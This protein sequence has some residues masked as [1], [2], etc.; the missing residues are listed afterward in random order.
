[1]SIWWL[2]THLFSVLGFVLAFLVLAGLPRERRAPSSTFAWLLVIVL[3]PYVGVP[4]Y[5]MFGPRKLR[6][7]ARGKEALY[8]PSSGAP[9][10]DAGHALERILRS[11]GAPRAIGGHRVELLATGEEAYRELVAM[12]E[13]AR[14]SIHIATFILGGDEVGRSILDLLERKAREGL[15]VRLL[16]DA[17]FG[18]RADRGGLERL[19]RAGGRYAFFMPVLHIPFRGQANLRN[20]RKI[21]LGDGREAIVGGMNIAREYMGPTPHPKRWRDVAVRIEGPTVPDLSRI[22]RLDWAFASKESLGEPAVDVTPKGSAH[23]QVAASGPD[24]PGDTIYDATLSALF[25]ARSRI[26]IATP[27]FIPDEAV[28]RGLV[29]AVRRGVDVR[30]VIPLRSNHWTADLAGG[31]YLRQVSDA[32]GR[33]LP[34]TG[35]MM[36]A[37]VA[38]IDETV[39][40]LGSANMD[41]RS[42]FVDYEVAL[43]FYSA[44]E[45]AL[46]A[47]WFEGLFRGCAESLSPASRARVLLENVGRLLA[48]LA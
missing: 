34:F 4:L 24:V 11:A 23:V 6:R 37:K 42:F 9:P 48:P 2:F 19:R 3:I 44:E 32:G 17:L 38:V 45:I 41:V 10:A 35:G 12:I 7:L 29:L 43:F 25:G 27:Y 26:W 16:I 8:L 5:L 1:V 33:V 47:G 31:S 36:H 28:A 18:F 40:V 22:F 46:V 15:E 21:W 20:H 14:R 30:I 39:G 13:R